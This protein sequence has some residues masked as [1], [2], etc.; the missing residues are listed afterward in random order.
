VKKERNDQS[1]ADPAEASLIKEARAFHLKKRLGQ[2]F[3]VRPEALET[4]ATAIEPQAKDTIIEVGPGI[5][6]LTR[7]L[8]PSGARIVAVDLDRESVEQLQEMNLPGVE[9]KHGDFLRFDLSNLEF[10]KRKRKT[11]Q[12]PLDLDDLPDDWDENLTDDSGENAG[13]NSE[14]S[15]DEPVEQPG[16]TEIANNGIINA[17]EKIKIIGNVP[18]QITG[19]II[20][21]ILGEISRPAPWLSKVE[22][23]VMTVQYEVALRMVANAGEEHY[24]KLSPL[25]R[26]F[27]EPELISRVPADAFYPIPEVNSAVVRMR[28]RAK[29]LVE[30][31]NVHLMQQLIEAGFRQRRKMFRNSIS[32]LK[33]APSDIERIFKELNVDPQVRAER[34][35]LQQFAML[36]DAFNELV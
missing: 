12:Q 24:S 19:L 3:L 33:F 5:G 15:S 13:E 11:I 29:P 27:C 23:I 36:A 8:S 1:T 34:L 7:M 18:Y 10:Y 4:I 17:T 30:C 14:G 35:S 9:I 2:H 31:K 16:Q 28:P 21:H 22:N 26:Y 20:G 25:I 6:F 32:F